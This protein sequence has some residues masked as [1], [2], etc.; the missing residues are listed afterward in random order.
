MKRIRKIFIAPGRKY[1]SSSITNHFELRCMSVFAIDIWLQKPINEN[2]M[3][4]FFWRNLVIKTKE[5]RQN[6]NLW[7]SCEFF[8]PAT[9][10]KTETLACTDVRTY[11]RKCQLFFFF[12]FFAKTVLK[13]DKNSTITYPR[14]HACRCKQLL[15]SYPSVFC[16][17][18]FFSLNDNNR[19]YGVLNC[20]ELSVY[21]KRSKP[22]TRTENSPLYHPPPPPLKKKK[23][24]RKLCVTS[25]TVC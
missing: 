13:G 15:F 6:A 18:F 2:F 20:A 8:S 4:Y 1:I 12:F 3:R 10:I 7:H 23:S 14:K 5:L 11:M 21:F 9:Y 22:L 16:F 24:A 17:L 25:I 19:M